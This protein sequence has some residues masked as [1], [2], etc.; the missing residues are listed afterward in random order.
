MRGRTKDES[1]AFRSLRVRRWLGSPSG[2]EIPPV[3]KAV[4]QFDTPLRRAREK[5]VSLP[6]LGYDES[7][8]Q[9]FE[10]LIRGVT[11]GDSLSAR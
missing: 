5:T 3:R 6:S 7:V 1:V 9:R 10:M 2:V 8:D 4:R 11:Q